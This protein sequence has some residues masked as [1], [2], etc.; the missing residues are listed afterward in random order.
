RMPQ[1]LIQNTNGIPPVTNDETHWEPRSDPRI[2]ETPPPRWEWV[3]LLLLLTGIM[4]L[5]LWAAIEGAMSVHAPEGPDHAR[6]PFPCVI[7]SA[8]ITRGTINEEMD[9]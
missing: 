4:G 7:K 6:S 5:I 8:T 2:C 3:V 1:I 9:L